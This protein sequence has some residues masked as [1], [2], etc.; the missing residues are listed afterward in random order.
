MEY[1]LVGRIPGLNHLIIKYLLCSGALVGLFTGFIACGAENYRA[2]LKDDIV[3]VTDN[4]S[5]SGNEDY[6][7]IH[8]KDG[9]INLPIPMK[10][11]ENV[12]EKNISM[13]KKAIHSW[14]TAIGKTLFNFTGTHKGVHGDSFT[15]LYDSLTGDSVNGHYFDYD[16][17]KTGKH[18]AVLGTTIWSTPLSTVDKIVT[19][20]IRYNLQEYIMGDALVDLSE[21][22]KIIVDLES[23][24]IHEAGHLLGLAHVDE[25]TDEYSIMNPSLFIG[26][27]LT[28]RIPSRGD[29]ERI[30]KIY[31]C[32]G[33]ACDVDA[34][35]LKLEEMNNTDSEDDE[36]GSGA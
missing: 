25:E 34:T 1:T 12:P 10:F 27:G 31:G 8:A 2:D 9:W 14:E 11:G 30:Q 18:K 17:D 19:A 33:D 22:N 13:I 20:D 36:D 6:Y 24:A 5:N 4:S 3:S 28:T 21:G 15:E 7:G 29:I 35:L 32:S 26:E 16:W 23:L